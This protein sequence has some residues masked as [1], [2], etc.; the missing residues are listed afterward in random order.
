MKIAIYP[1]SF[2][3]F[4]KGHLSIVNKALKIF[5]FVYIIVTLNPDKKNPNNLEYNKE[6]IEEYFKNN[7]RV[8]VLI[9]KSKLTGTLALELGAQFLIRSSRYNLDFEYEL[10]L[11]NSNNFINNNLETIIFFPD[12]DHKHVSSTVI[13]HKKAIEKK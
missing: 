6:I 13:R 9:N 12:Y 4:H 1:G 11:A 2:N 10:N 3:P 7:E 8:I 5:D